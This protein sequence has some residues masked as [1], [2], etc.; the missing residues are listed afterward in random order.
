VIETTL[1]A[2]AGSRA[3]HL[4]GIRP[5]LWILA[6]GALARLAVFYLFHNVELHT[7]EIQYQEIAVNLVQGHGFMMEGR[8]TSW[9]PPL[10]PFLMS[11]LYWI[12]GTTDPDVV[13]AFQAALSLGTVAVVYGLARE[14]FGPRV[15]PLAAA[16]VALYPSLLFYNNHL[17]AEVLFIFLCTLTAYGFVAHLRAPRVGTLMLTG[18]SLGLSVLTRD[19][20]WPTVGIMVVLMKYATIMPWRRWLVHGTGLVAI[21]LVLTVP[22]VVRNTRLQGTFTLIATNGG[23]VF[24]AGN[25]ENTPHDRPWR[26]HALESHLK[27]AALFPKDL[28]EGVTQKLAVRRALAFIQEHPWLTVRNAVIR[29]ANVWGLEREVIGVFL[30]GIYGPVGTVSVLLVTALIF[31]GYIAVAL[32]SAAG[33]CFALARGG[34]SMGAHLYVAALVVFV[35]LAHAPVSGHPRYHLPLIPLLAVYAAYAWM[36]RRDLWTARR[37]WPMR[38][39]SVCA[40]LFAV[41]WVREVFFVEMDR[42]FK[43][44]GWL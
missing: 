31:A 2:R 14:V 42:Y 38:V 29:I 25:Y 22:W 4:E 13:R 37:T 6:A 41:A 3:H 27:V 40:G 8:L 12:T 44:L 9:R 43:A 10:Y 35:T 36:A 17:L 11:V 5:L 23:L 24:L 30:K 32:A 7:D 21:L 33:L 18:V 34:S 1:S 15:A 19:I 20:V 39:A 16:I 26:S 28:S